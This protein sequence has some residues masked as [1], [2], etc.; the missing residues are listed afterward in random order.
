MPVDTPD[1]P[2]SGSPNREWLEQLETDLQDQWPIA[3]PTSDDGIRVLLNACLEFQEQFGVSY[4]VLPLPVI[5]DPDSSLER[6]RQWLEQAVIC[7]SSTDLPVLV[8]VAVSDVCL[9]YRDP[10]D[11]DL[12]EALVDNLAVREEL[13]GVYLVLIQA[14]GED[15]AVYRSRIAWSLLDFCH[16]IGNWASR[17]VIVNYV[18]DFGWVCTAAGA[19]GFA[20]GYRTKERRLNLQDYERR[21]GGGAFPRFYSNT[22]MCHYLPERDLKRLRDRRLLRFLESDQTVA[23]RGLFEALASGRSARDVPEW[24]E[25]LNNVAAAES[26]RMQ[27]LHGASQ[28]MDALPESDRAR[29]MYRHLQDA[30]QTAVYF[31]TIFDEDP[32]DDSGRHL[33]PWRSGFERFMEEHGL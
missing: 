27:L 13:S 3:V 25:S 20:A 19:S 5:D 6:H 4:A 16:A 21:S 26:H 11:N 22:T 17:T 30:E 32:L 10:P 14:V 18:D 9:L 28:A 7:A 24:R 1:L 8:Q 15:R 29:E 2:D 23:A 12:L 31:N 33:T